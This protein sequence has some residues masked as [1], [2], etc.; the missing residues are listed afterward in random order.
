ME[1]EQQRVR[2]IDSTY[3]IEDM[4]MQ[5]DESNVTARKS[6][7]ELRSAVSQLETIKEPSDAVKQVIATLKTQVEDVGE[8]IRKN[9]YRCE[10]LKPVL[11][12]VQRTKIGEDNNV[13][14]IIS[15]LL[16]AMGVVNRDA[17]PFEERTEL[18]T[19]EQKEKAKA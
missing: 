18:K 16:E 7:E 4:I 3:I 15:M 17:V 11:L 10:C 9:T 19:E 1:N 6:L 13:R 5:F 2:F 12:L 8:A 14:Y